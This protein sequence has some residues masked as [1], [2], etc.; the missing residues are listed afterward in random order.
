LRPDLCFEYISTGIFPP[1]LP[2]LLKAAKLH[3]MANEVR[4]HGKR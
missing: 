2:S 1:S 4:D 3:A